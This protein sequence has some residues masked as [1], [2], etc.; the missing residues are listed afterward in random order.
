MN[1]TV[2]VK[3]DISTP[4]GR[5]LLRDLKDQKCV[6]IE[7]LPQYEVVGKTYPLEEVYEELKASLKA[8]YEAK[9]KRSDEI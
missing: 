2:N 6:E 3:I 9:E 8:H 4:K 1:N 5:K 7:N